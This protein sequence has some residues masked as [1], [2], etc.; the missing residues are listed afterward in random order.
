VLE[1]TFTFHHGYMSEIELMGDNTATGI[2]AM[3]DW[4]VFVNGS[5]MRGWGTTT[6]A[7]AA[8]TTS[9]GSMSWPSPECGSTRP[10]LTC[11]RYPP[12]S[13]LPDE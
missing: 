7:T 3:H 9:G 11:P 10:L 8:W 5:V 1:G 4:L 6:R 2:W 13:G 12:A